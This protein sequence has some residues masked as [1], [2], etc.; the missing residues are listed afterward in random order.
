MHHTRNTPR[1]EREQVFRVD[2]TDAM[3]HPRRW[4]VLPVPAEFP[5][6]RVT[7]AEDVLRKSDKVASKC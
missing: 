3:L 1:T 6:E 5:S 2:A 7:N 4:T